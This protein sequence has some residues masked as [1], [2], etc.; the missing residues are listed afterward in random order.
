M[1]F[2]ITLLISPWKQ[3]TSE[4][5]LSFLNEGMKS[6]GA[7]ALVKRDVIAKYCQSKVY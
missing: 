6:I 7:T 2:G 4:S 5:L 3:T 1:S